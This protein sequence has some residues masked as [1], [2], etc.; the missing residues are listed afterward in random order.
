MIFNI[1]G[2]PNLASHVW[3]E[4]LGHVFFLFKI[5]FLTTVWLRG[6]TVAR[7]TPDQKATC[8]NRVGI[9]YILS[10]GGFLSRTDSIE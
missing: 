2:N 7:L 10:Y 8:S 6:A 9:K 5:L 1:G 4:Q 3:A